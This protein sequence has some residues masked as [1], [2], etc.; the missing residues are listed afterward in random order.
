MKYILLLA[1]I[2][3][4]GCSNEISKTQEEGHQGPNGRDR[5]EDYEEALQGSFTRAPLHY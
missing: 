2:L 3:L 1:V 4:S 5:K